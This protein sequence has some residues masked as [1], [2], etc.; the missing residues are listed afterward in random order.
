MHGTHYD[1]VNESD[2]DYVLYKDYA[3]LENENR[4]LQAKVLSRDALIEHY[5]K[6]NK[7]LM[8]AK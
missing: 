1:M 6:E 4:L 8:E 5:D 3:A 2:G 7:R